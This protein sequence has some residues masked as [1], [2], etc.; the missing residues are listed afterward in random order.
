MVDVKFNIRMFQQNLVKI[1]N[2]KLHK[3]PLS[4]SSFI[5]RAERTDIHEEATG[6]LSELLCENTQKWDTFMLNC[7]GQA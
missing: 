5:Q 6:R 7:S 1:R 3:N 4:E 2:M